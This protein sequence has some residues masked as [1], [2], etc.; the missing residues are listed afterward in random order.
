MNKRLTRDQVESLLATREQEI[1]EL[2]R[3]IENFNN[4]DFYK[5]EKEYNR[6]YVDGM[7]RVIEMIE[8]ILVNKEE[9]L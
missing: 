2:E 4:I 7:T 1:L 9:Q 8:K 3:K 5:S 6:G